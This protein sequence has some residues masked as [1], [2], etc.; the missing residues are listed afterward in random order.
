MAVHTRGFRE[1]HA[2]LS[3]ELERLRVLAERYPELTEEQRRSEHEQIV[4]FLHDKVEPHTKL[5]ERLLYPEVAERLGDALVAT[6]MNYDH[7]AIRHWIAELA[8]ADPH[9][10][11]HLQ[12]LLYGLE[13]IIRVHIWKEEELFVKPLESGS[14]PSV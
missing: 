6:S 11:A 3:T 12:Q 7:L 14:W 8:T 9:E 2:G 5:D 10:T 13:A 1:A 4:A